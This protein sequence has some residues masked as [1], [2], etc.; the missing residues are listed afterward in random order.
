[1]GGDIV[2]VFPGEHLGRKGVSVKTGGPLDAPP[3]AGAAPQVLSYPA[4][5]GW[6]WSLKSSV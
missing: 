2:G 6:T 5:D 3:P 1:M 4:Q